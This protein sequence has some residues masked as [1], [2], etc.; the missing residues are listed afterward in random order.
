[1][2]IEY[3]H[4]NPTSEEILSQKNDFSMSQT[5]AKNPPDTF[6]MYRNCKDEVETESNS[7]LS[8]NSLNPLADPSWK[9]LKLD[10][11]GP[12]LL[13]THLLVLA[14]TFHWNRHCHS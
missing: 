1:M 12:N 8:S 4:I 14:E 9:A 13:E 6:F 7:V 2:L 10:Q 5:S 3:S 11:L